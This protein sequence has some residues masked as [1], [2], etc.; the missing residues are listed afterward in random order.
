MPNSHN[1]SNVHY[2]LSKFTGEWFT[3]HSNHIHRF[4]PIT[5]IVA[6]KVRTSTQ[7]AIWEVWGFN[8]RFGDLSFLLDDCFRQPCRQIRGFGHVPLPCRWKLLPEEFLG[9]LYANKI[10]ITYSFIVDNPNILGNFCCLLGRNDW[11]R[12]T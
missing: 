1:H 4:T 12:I 9:R 5:R 2:S 11:E 10:Y 8:G 7:A 6:T 3:N